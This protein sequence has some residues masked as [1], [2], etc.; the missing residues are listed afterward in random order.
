MRQSASAIK[1]MKLLTQLV[2]LIF[3]SGCAVTANQSGNNAADGTLPTGTVKNTGGV[4]Q[5]T[6][7]EWHYDTAEKRRSWQAAQVRIPDGDIQKIIIEFLKAND[8]TVLIP[9]QDT[10]KT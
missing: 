6:P 3:I 8:L 9:K 1:P 7:A 5:Q 2:T 10:P 4:A